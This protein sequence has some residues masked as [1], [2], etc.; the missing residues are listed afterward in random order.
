MVPLSP[1]PL[2]IVLGGDDAGFALKSVI[3]SN[4]IA[5]PHVANVTDIGPLST[6]DKTAYPHFAEIGRAHV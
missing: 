3:N 5:S 4:L 1:Q 2:R 6:S